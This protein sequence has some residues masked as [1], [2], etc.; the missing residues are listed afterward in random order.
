MSDNSSMAIGLLYP[1]EMGMSVARVLRGRGFRVVTAAAKR[2][3]ATRAR[4]AAAG[5]DDLGSLEAVVRESQVVISLVPPDAAE[6]TATGYCELAKHAPP[7]AIFVDANSIGPALAMRIAQ[8]IESRGVSFVDG[9]INGL[10]RNLTTSGTLFLSGAR[11]GQVE[12]LFGSDVR[13]RVLGTEPGRASAM[14]M[15]LSGMS[16]G[17]CALY[18]ELALVARQ[19]AM[20][21]EFQQIATEIYPGIMSLVD[22]MLPTYSAHAIRRAAEMNE[23]NTTTQEAGVEPCVIEAV[24]RIHEV[25][26]ITDFGSS[27][28]PITI[29]GLIEKV[30]AGLTAEAGTKPTQVVND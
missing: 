26:A 25:L 10:A 19:S 22:R 8:M 27:D 17:I 28:A 29:E 13:I 15:L 3:A 14:K 23:L 11:A 4:C 12:Q 30:A 18:V 5:V 6:E 2:S 9:A 16:K 1:G 21:P 24:G 7:G 20:L